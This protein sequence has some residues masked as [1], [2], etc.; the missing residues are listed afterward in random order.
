MSKQTESHERRGLPQALAGVAL[1]AEGD[2][3]FIEGYAAVFYREDDLGTEFELWEGAVERILPG[4][5]DKALAES[6]CRC[7]FNHASD[8]I[9]GRTKS[10]TCTL[11]VDEIGL[12]YRVELPDTTCG[13]DCRISIERGDVDGSSFGF[14]VRSQNRR[15]ES[16]GKTIRELLEIFPLYDVGP[17]TFPA[18]KATTTEVARRHLADAAHQERERLKRGA[19]R[20]RKLH[21]LK[22]R[23]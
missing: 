7:L 3:H 8:N 18:Y 2:R 15:E 21:W 4:A 6:D 1:R 16:D 13:R 22:R 9:L 5:F 20:Q 17:V 19:D 12:R 14:D 23:R 11:S 10:K